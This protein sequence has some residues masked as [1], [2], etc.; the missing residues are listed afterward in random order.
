[1]IFIFCLYETVIEI[2]SNFLGGL[3]GQLPLISTT[4]GIVSFLRKEGR[5]FICSMA[6]ENFIILLVP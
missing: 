5:I 3:G 4:Y 6:R 2:G 1:M